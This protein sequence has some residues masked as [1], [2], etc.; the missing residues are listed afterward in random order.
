MV[1]AG[2]DPQLRVG[3]TGMIDVTYAFTRTLANTSLAEARERIVAALQKEGFGI[4]TEIDVK[5]TFKKKLDVDFRP[6][7]ILGACN[8]PIA[9]KA[10]SLDL[11]MGLLLPCNVVVTETD[12]GCAVVSVIKPEAM[13]SLIENPAFNPLVQE[14]TEKLT[15]A[16]DAA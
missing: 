14:V 6:Y 10:L 1:R 11:G 16:L 13:F 8:P 9:H 7:L 15:R 3:G 5:A 12:D 2:I 4:L